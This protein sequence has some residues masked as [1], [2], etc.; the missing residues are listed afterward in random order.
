MPDDSERLVVLLEARLTDF[1]RNMLKAAGISRTQ[2]NTIKA[3]SRS[4][5]RQM[6]A[7]MVRSTT[8]INQAL[9][10]TSSRLGEF[11]KS[12]AIAFGAGISFRGAE[13][14]LDDATKIQNAL[15][16][17]G[18]AG[19]DLKKVYDA[20]FASAM[21]NAAPFETLVQL[22]SRASLQQKE[23]GISTEQLLDFTDKVALALRVQG[24]DAATASGA[25]L[26]LSQALGSGVVHAQEFNSILEGV[27]TIAQAAAAGI[28]EAGGSV[29]KLRTLVISGKVSSAAFFA[30]FEAGA[31]ILQDR[32]AGAAF[33]VGQAF[34][35]LNTVLIDIATKFNEGTDAS[36]KLADLLNGPLTNAIQEIGEL[37]SK[38]S[39]GPIG[40]FVGM[41]NNAVDNLLRASEAFGKATGLSKIGEAAGAKPYSE[42]T[43]AGKP[44]S[45]AL[46][47][48]VSKPAPRKQISLADYPA[49]GTGSGNG[50]AARRNAYERETASIQARTKAIEAQ[51]AAQASINPLIDDFGKAVE[52]ASAKQDL[53]NAAQQAGVK[54]TPAISASIDDLA[55]KYGDAYAAAQKLAK[56][57]DDIR[58]AAE[59]NLDAARGVVK[60]VVDDLRAGKSAGD[61]FADAISRIADRIEDQL[62]DAI[63]KVNG[64]SSG[65][66]GGFLGF[67]FQGLGSLLGGFGGGVSLPA[68][69]PIPTP[70]PALA[71]GTN[72]APG[73]PSIINER[74]GEIVDLPRGSRVIPHDVSMAMA[75]N[76]G[77]QKVDMNLTVVVQGS[78]DKELMTNMKAGAE[79]AAGRVLKKYR[80][81]M[82]MTADVAGHLQRGKTRGYFKL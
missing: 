32:V 50:A 9:A 39:N 17:T 8:R 36:Q 80:G 38:V 67:L 14:L 22:Y 25:L 44:K 13:E 61:I 1:E 7:D 57:Q 26:Q 45:G 43:D 47:L 77:P 23:L 59:E 12:F 65:S 48:T 78:G 18:L 19:E 6:E 24:T 82:A 3:N 64:A 52:T 62:L 28:K 58:Q 49:N 40:Q 81:S 27:P 70:R 34:G 63:F 46:E 55:A 10:T 41:I 5:T 42:I 33:T 2:F 66:G 68:T 21:K 29:A 20:L 35:N 69:A 75:R 60:G 11:G 73:G 71:N 56:S 4:A 15:K 16:V 76:S 74:G 31:S 72:F 30:G 53:L 51:T 79:E 54:I 37:F